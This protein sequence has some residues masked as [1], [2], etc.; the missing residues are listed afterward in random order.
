MATF[1][2]QGGSGGTIPA[3]TVMVDAVTGL[4][5][6]QAGAAIVEA[7]V[8]TM[9]DLIL[10]TG[11]TYDD[12]SILVKNPANNVSNYFP[13]KAFRMNSRWY[14]ENG[15]ALLYA[16][17]PRQRFTWP[18]A[19]W[20][21]GGLA[22]AVSGLGAGHTKLTGTAG[23]ALT[24]AAQI[25]AGDTY[26]YISGSVAATGTIDWPVGWI[27]L[28]AITDVGNDLTVLYP[29]DANLKEPVIAE[30]GAASK[31]PALVIS[32]PPLAEH[33]GYEVYLSGKNIV[34]ANEHRL[35]AY[36][37]A[38]GTT[39]TQLYAQDAV[40]LAV[41]VPAA[42]VSG[43]MIFAND[44]A[45]APTGVRGGLQN[46]GATNVNITV[47]PPIS[48]SGSGIGTGLTTYNAPALQ[49]NVPTEL[50]ITVESATGIDIT[51]ELAAVTVRW[52]Y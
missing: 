27:K 33:G 1:P 6:T 37:A 11:A 20:N 13:A 4:F 28:T 52:R 21:N 7:S 10:L 45:A 47:G 34:A 35:A 9:A 5:E 39:I 12:T 23:H 32:I 22:R 8:T 16:K 18:A 42:P 14:L 31:A 25:T 30:I 49:T 51:M 36:A 26:V 50:I 40:I 19:V 44:T 3:N 48:T 38:V 24:T 2:G 15:D 43:R 29:Y 46:V 41:V 17:A